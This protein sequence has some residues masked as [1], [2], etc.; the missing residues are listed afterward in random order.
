MG[1]ILTSVSWLKDTTIAYDFEM[2]FWVESW[3]KGFIQSA[4]MTYDD[5]TNDWSM[6]PALWDEFEDEQEKNESET[7]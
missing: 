7:G 6:N 1:S 3:P 5:Y 4:G 2:S